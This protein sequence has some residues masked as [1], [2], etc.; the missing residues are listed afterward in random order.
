LV[1][2][3]VLPPPEPPTEVV[4]EVPPPE[5]GFLA[6]RLGA[7]R[8]FEPLVVFVVVVVVVVVL[9]GTSCGLNW[10]GP[11]VVEVDAVVVEV[12]LATVAPQPLSRAAAHSAATMVRREEG[13][14]AQRSFG[15]GR[16]G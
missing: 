13:I 11:G 9:D 7:V 3:T 6:A 14:A 4:P 10:F 2:V 15:F 8:G 1:T 5:L 16:F 12:L